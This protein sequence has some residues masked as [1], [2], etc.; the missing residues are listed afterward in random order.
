MLKKA[1]LFLIAALW[2]VTNAFPIS[3]QTVGT[4]TLINCYHAEELVNGVWQTTTPPAPASN[5]CEVL[6]YAPGHSSIGRPLTYDE[7]YQ[8]ADWRLVAGGTQYPYGPGYR[9]TSGHFR[10]EGANPPVTQPLDDIQQLVVSEP[11]LGM[12]IPPLTENQPCFDLFTT[13]EV[14]D[15]HQIFGWGEDEGDTCLL[16]DGE[17]G[18]LYVLATD[19]KEDGT[20]RWLFDINWNVTQHW[21]S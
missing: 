7:A 15:E 9:F 6:M 13:G 3:A 5:G 8:N 19:Q 11:P 20:S 14:G 4:Y 2:V 17:Y 1:G 12:V 21:E 16:I 18:E 10:Y